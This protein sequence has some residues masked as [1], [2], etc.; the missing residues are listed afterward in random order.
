MG[1]CCA[2]ASSYEQMEK[3]VPD[4]TGPAQE[5]L[6]HIWIGDIDSLANAEDFDAVI[7]AV[8]PKRMPRSVRYRAHLQVPVE[9][10]V[11]APIKNYFATAADFIHEHVQRGQNVLV[12]C[13]AGVSRSTTL[14]IAYMMRYRGYNDPWE[15]LHV[16]QKK[17]PQ[18]RPNDGFM[19]QLGKWRK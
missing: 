14:V 1:S 13:M 9:D 19:I 8:P 17:R 7:S 10:E 2:R 3:L 6:P 4:P 12:H 15:A 18:V 5:V 16:L 11:N